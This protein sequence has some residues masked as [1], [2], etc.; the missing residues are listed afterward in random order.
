METERE[1]TDRLL[2]RNGSGRKHFRVGNSWGVYDAYKAIRKGGWQ[3]LDR[4]LTE[5]EFYSIVRGINSLLAAEIAKGNT[6]RLPCRMGRLELVKSEGGPYMKDGKVV[7][8]SPVD[9]KKTLQLWYE[10]PEAREDRTLIR[11]R[12]TYTYRVRYRKGKANYGNKSFYQF[13]LN[14]RIKLQLKD[15][16]NEGDIDTPWLQTY[17][18]QA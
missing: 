18:T 16:I 9:W 6:V 12:D 17:N 10:D 5:H 11:R 3:G 4:P 7:N 8:H 13:A 2:K 14:R 1:H 15:N